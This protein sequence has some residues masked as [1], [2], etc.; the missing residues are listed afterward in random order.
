MTTYADTVLADSPVG[1]WK[2]DDGTGATFADS[3]GNGHDGTID[4]GD[5]SNPGGTA[6]QWSNG[7]LVPNA[8]PG[9]SLLFFARH[10]YLAR[11]AG[12]GSLIND[13]NGQSIELWYEAVSSTVQWS[14]QHFSTVG[15]EID[16]LN[17]DGKS[18]TGFCESTRHDALATIPAKGVHQLV[19]TRK[20]GGQYIVYIDGAQAA[21]VAAGTYH[22]QTDL[23]IGGNPNAGSDVLFAGRI[24]QVSLYNTQLSA[25]RV[26]AHYNAGLVPYVPVSATL[27]H[28]DDLGRGYG[29]NTFQ[30]GAQDTGAEDDV[31]ALWWESD[32]AGWWERN[33]FHVEARAAASAAWNQ[34]RS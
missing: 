2:L 11:V 34:G 6:P 1:Y 19:I 17:G 10:V 23:S 22:A 33:P 20:T 13:T 21:T 26:L 16:R 15:D 28:G 31:F 7:S 32:M 29:P 4:A 18:Y 12:V 27:S 3:S 24:S 8:G 14:V 9:S 30:P 5:G 25:G